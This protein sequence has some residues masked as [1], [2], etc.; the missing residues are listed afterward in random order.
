M[1]DQHLHGFLNAAAKGL[2]D[3]FT[4]FFGRRMGFVVLIAPLGDEAGEQLHYVCNV[5]R[6]DAVT[7]MLEFVGKQSPERLKQAIDRIQAQMLLGEGAE[8]AQ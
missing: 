8:R 3:I 7:A 5:D 4:E 2:D 6:D 1:P